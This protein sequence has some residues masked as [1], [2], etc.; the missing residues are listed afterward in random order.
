MPVAPLGDHRVTIMG[1]SGDQAKRRP[2]CQAR[3]CKLGGHTMTHEFLYLPDCPIPLLGRDL[4][5]KLGAQ[6]SFEPSGQASMSLQPPSEGLIL[7]I[8]TPRE[9]EWRLYGTGSVEQ[10][11]EA[12]RADF[13]EVWAEGKTALEGLL[14]KNFY[15][16]QLSAL[17]KPI[18]ERCLT[19]A[20]SNPTSSPSPIPGI[21]RSG[22]APFE[23][24]KVDFTNM[25]NCRGT[26]YLPVLVCTYSGWV[27]VFPT[28]TEKSCEVAKVPLREIIPRY[29]IPLPI[30]SDNRPAFIAELLQTVTRAMGINW[31]LHTA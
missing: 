30:H 20:K 28:Q 5:T 9:E 21:Q 29:G 26:K 14:A 13:P 8:T 19:C 10:N 22:A 18:G 11:P 7:S 2:F 3:T 6:I 16:S 15:I 17:R 24:V 23:D 4:L 31:R 27:K 1:T 12:Y 25:T